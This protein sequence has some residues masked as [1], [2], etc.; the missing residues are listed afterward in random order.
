MTFVK[1]QAPWNKG[2]TGYEMPP[3]SEE[4]KR[5][6]SI[7]L[8][9]NKHFRGKTHT[10]ETKRKMSEIR[11]GIKFSDEHLKKLSESHM[12]NKLLPESIQRRTETRKKNGYTHT[13]E[14][15]RKI[16][17]PQRGELNHNWNNGSSFKPYCLK[18]NDEFKEMIRDRFNRQCFLCGISESKQMESQKN[19]GKRE[20]R[21]SIHHVNYD[22]NCLCDDSKCEFVPLC[23]S[24]HMKTNS[25][26]EYWE[27]I[28]MDKLNEIGGIESIKSFRSRSMGQRSKIASLK[29]TDAGVEVIT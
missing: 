27:E 8:V 18:F 15:R 7:A 28:F 17:E 14:T 10:E 3:A 13:K 2:I 4:R 5:K 9:G 20:F 29:I 23:H 1:G 22:K 26:R 21:L 25:N 11:K 12:G 16:G 19:N 6:I 24:C